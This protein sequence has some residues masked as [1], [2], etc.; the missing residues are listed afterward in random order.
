MPDRWAAWILEHRFGGDAQQR[1]RTMVS[2]A[3]VRD[4]VLAG[5]RINPGDVVLDVGCGDGLLG[6]AAL[7]AVTE[8]G[9]VVFS[10]ISADLLDQCRTI[11]ADLGLSSRAIFVHT[12]L[13]A[14]AE[15]ES[16]SVDVAMTRSV[17]I[18]V[19]DKAASFAALHRVLRP[20]G[21]LSIFEPINRFGHPEPAN[22]LLGLD[23]AGLEPYAEKVKS[24]YRGHQPEGDPMLDFDE[25]DLLTYAEDAGFTQ[26]HLDYHADVD[27]QPIE[28]SWPVLLRSAPNPLVPVL[29]DVLDE[30]LDESER[31]VLAERLQRELAHGTTRRRLAT[32]YLSAVR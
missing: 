3:A 2:L 18:Y 13:P 27:R 9:R 6:V 4:R 7:D 26:V 14:L 5:A 21:R 31:A 15:I 24:V 25:R 8:S 29:G 20:G 12:G 28:F 16:G 19:R 1:E 30:A 10:D 23:I 32:V 17:L 22:F 11:T